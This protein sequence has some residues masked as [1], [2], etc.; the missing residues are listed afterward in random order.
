VQEVNTERVLQLCAERE[1]QMLALYPVLLATV[2]LSPEPSSLLQRQQ[3]RLQLHH[4]K[5]QWVRQHWMER[6]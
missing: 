2:A 4:A 6:G 1:Q 5:L 3:H